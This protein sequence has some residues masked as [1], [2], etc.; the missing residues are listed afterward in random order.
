LPCAA[1]FNALL[2]ICARTKDETRGYEV[3]FSLCSLSQV[4]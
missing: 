1:T 4:A 3:G 2:E